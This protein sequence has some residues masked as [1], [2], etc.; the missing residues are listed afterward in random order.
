MHCSVID[1]SIIKIKTHD[2][3]IFLRQIPLSGYIIS[4][5]AISPEFEFLI[6]VGVYPLHF[7]IILG[8]K[9]DADNLYDSSWP[10]I[11][12]PLDMYIID[13]ND[14]NINIGSLEEFAKGQ[15]TKITNPGELDSFNIEQMCQRINII[16]NNKL[17]YNA[18]ALN[19]Q[20]FALYILKGQYTSPSK[21]FT[22][23]LIL[24]ITFY[25]LFIHY[26]RKK[27]TFVF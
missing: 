8:L 23:L 3:E 15:P 10:I 21:N 5:K 24:L 19:C 2:K 20:T 13:F 1:S 16:T 12:D 9:L 17:Y 4:R 25:F 14:K 27:N 7:G 22:I 11:T 26:N 18:F 6:N